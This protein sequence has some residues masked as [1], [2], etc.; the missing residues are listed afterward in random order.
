[1]ILKDKNVVDQMDNLTKEELIN[2]VLPN[3]R[4]RINE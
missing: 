1:M 4:N 2:K 3:F